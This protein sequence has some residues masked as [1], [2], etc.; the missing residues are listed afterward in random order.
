MS[1]D[2]DIKKELSANSGDGD[3]E[4]LD[5][6]PRKKISGKRLILFV[7]LPLILIVG[8]VSGLYFSGILSGLFGHGEQH[9]EG[10]L[11]EPKL[12]DDEPEGPTFF[13][14]VPDIIVNLSTDGGKK[15]RFLKLSV[16][17]ELVGETAPAEMDKVMPR[18]IDQFQTFLRELRVSDMQ[19]S[20][21]VYRIRQE[22]LER[23]RV[24]AH[25]TYVRDVLFRDILIQ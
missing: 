13:Y 7:V 9:V 24:A 16:T 6:L 3:I 15:Q 17:L 18:V 25:P 22:L 1:D 2:D 20:A 23:V 19:G 12:V 5:D 11:D 21:G 4:N 8:G 10:G 14:E